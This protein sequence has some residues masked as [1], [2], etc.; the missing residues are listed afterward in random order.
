MKISAKMKQK[1]RFDKRRKNYEKK[2]TYDDVY[3]FTHGV[4]NNNIVEKTSEK[5]IGEWEVISGS[6]FLYQ[7]NDGN[8]Y[9]EE[10]ASDKSQ[11]LEEQIGRAE[12]QVDDLQEEMDKDIQIVICRRQKIR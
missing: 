10:E 4:L 9:T 7:D 8:E 2:Y 6:L 11:E 12:S 5:E 3:N 1:Y